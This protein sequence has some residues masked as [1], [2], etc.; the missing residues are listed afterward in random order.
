MRPQESIDYS[1]MS[2]EEAVQSMY[3][4][5]YDRNPPGL[6]EGLRDIGMMAATPILMFGAPAKALQVGRLALGSRAYKAYSFVKRPVLTMAVNANVRGAKAAMA[7]S[8]A[9][10]KTI[11]VLGALDFKRNVE[12]IRQREWKRLGINLYGPPGSL[13]YYDN[14]MSGNSETAKA[15]RDAVAAKSRVGS[16][17]PSKPKTRGKRKPNLY[18]PKPGEKC[19]PGYVRIDG[20]CV[21][22]NSTLHKSLMN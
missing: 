3:G 9:Y 4:K 6:K 12:L 16:S 21:L 19:R 5:T 2:H 11:A 7:V 13:W 15:K 18:D 1:D 20:R 17:L 8:K 14:H 10:G 22:R